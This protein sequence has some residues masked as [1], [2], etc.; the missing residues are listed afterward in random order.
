MPL[1]EKLS[2]VYRRRH[3]FTRLVLGLFL[4]M[5]VGFKA[6]LIPAHLEVQGPRPSIFGGSPLAL[7]LEV[8]SVGLIAW[9]LGALWLVSAVE[10]WHVAQ[11]AG[12]PSESSIR[13]AMVVAQRFPMRMALLATAAEWFSFVGWMTLSTG[14]SSAL[15][16]VLFMAAM[17]SGSLPLA[18]SL[19]TWLIGPVMRGISLAARARGIVTPAPPFTLRGKLAFYSVTLCLTPAFYMAA[20]AFSAHARSGAPGHLLAAALIFFAAILPFGIICAALFAAT[21]TGPI[22]EMATVMRAIARQGDVSSV[23][24]VPLYDRDELGTLADVT[25]QMIDRLDLAETDR[26][27]SV[28]ALAALNQT[29]ELRVAQRTEELSNRSADMRLLLDNVDQGFFT[30]DRSGAMSPEHSAILASWFG[31]IQDGEPIHQYFQR[32]APDFADELALAWQQLVDDVIPTELALEQMPQR[33]VCAGRSHRFSYA[34]I[35]VGQVDRFLV[36][37][38]D[39]TRAVDHEL[40][41]HE[42]QET[43]ALFEHM[44]A[45]RNGFIVFME[46]ASE[47]VSRIVTVPIDDPVGF[48]RALHTLKGNAALFGLDSVAERCHALES[49]MAE[50]RT[51]PDPS[52]LADLHERWSRLAE[53]VDRLLGKGRPAIEVSP[54]QYAALDAA[55][56]GLVPHDQLL[57][58]LHDLTLEPVERR[59]QQLAEQAPRIARRLN[60]EISIELSHDDLRLDA[61]RWSKVWQAFVHAVRNA[62]DHGIESADERVAAGTPR[63]GQLKLRAVRAHGGVVIEIEDDGRGIRWDEI[64]DRLNALG[65]PAASHQQLVASLFVGGVSTAR[66][67]TETSGRGV[68]MGALRSAVQAMGGDIEIESEPGRGTLLRMRFPDPAV[69]PPTTTPP[70]PVL[71]ISAAVRTPAD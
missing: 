22:A 19:S 30:V 36:V 21:I 13:R 61:R 7:C 64:R 70:Q 52:Q 45:D 5:D 10:R 1:G 3:G 69:S 20:V 53:Q 71:R 54:Q 40:L 46:E 59:L 16:P 17:A 58:M 4:L 49:Y 2:A 34:P 9:A 24:R 12:A 65:L 67:I 28:A 23:G 60:K 62:I 66:E 50:E 51:L 6:L 35:G 38:S 26:A 63:A 31:P 25:N 29:L 14:G 47:I 18:H 39:E 8:S 44:L 11:L 27:A 32:H 68:G 56:R 43:L 37:V 33:L 55:V 41:Q 48:A 15:V 42:K 57:R